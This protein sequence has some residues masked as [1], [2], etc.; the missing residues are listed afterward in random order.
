M[1]IL[2]LIFTLSLLLALRFLFQKCIDKKER[3]VF[4][5]GLSLKIISALGIGWLYQ[6]HYHG[7]DTFNYLHDLELLAT[8]SS[9]G[10]FFS[11]QPRAWFFVQLIY[12]I[13]RLSDS[14]YW[15]LA[16]QLS[17]I[18]FL[19]TWFFYLELKR[20]HLKKWTVQIALFFIPSVVFWTSGL[21]KETISFAVIN[22]LFLILLR[23]RRNAPF[24]FVYLLAFIGLSTFLFYLKYYLFA[25]LVVLSLVFFVIHF[26]RKKISNI[27]LLVLSGLLVLVITSAIS[28]LHPNMQFDFFLEALHHNHTRTSN[29][30]SVQALINISYDG[31]LLS[32]L[33]NIPNA[34][35]TGLF[36]PILVESWSVFS[37]L[38]GI[39][40][41]F[42]LL[43]LSYTI[44]NKPQINHKTLLLV[45]VLFILFL[46]IILPIASP[47]FG[48]LVRYRTAYYP[49]FVLLLLNGSTKK[50][51]KQSV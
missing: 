36:R 48:S 2:T 41:T 12:P 37:L 45:S 44:W 34:L 11:D 15:F 24:L 46:A 10:F 28:I 21:M 16:I 20:L 51:V 23:V 42:T 29:H 1:I 5:L 30:S 22:L 14:N 35:F 9:Q 31:T 25:P 19:S 26:T 47:N 4:T 39:E 8:N 43:F 32:F 17:T 18:S 49:L 38:L 3:L 13:Y 7:G 50:G 6:N 33:K 40:N 27:T